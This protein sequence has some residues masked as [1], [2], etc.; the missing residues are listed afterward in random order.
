MGELI[1]RIQDSHFLISKLPGSPSRTYVESLGK[2]RDPTCDLKA[3]SGKLDIERHS[4]SILYL[5][6]HFHPEFLFITPFGETFEQVHA[7]MY[8]MH[9]NANITVTLANT[10][11]SMYQFQKRYLIYRVFDMHEF[12]CFIEIIKRVGQKR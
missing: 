3:F 10:C 1:N 4:L 5:S 6:L 7:W 8:V 9:I 2:P 12:S 11:V